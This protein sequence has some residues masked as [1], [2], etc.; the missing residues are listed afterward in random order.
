MRRLAGDGMAGTT[1]TTTTM[2]TDQ[3]GDQP[4]REGRQ[5]EP[6]DDDDDGGDLKEHLKTGSAGNVERRPGQTSAPDGGQHWTGGRHQKAANMNTRGC[7]RAGRRPCRHLEPSWPEGARGGSSERADAV[8]TPAHS[9]T[10]RF[11]GNT[12]TESQSRALERWG[13]VSSTERCVRKVRFGPMFPIARAFTL[14][15]VR[16]WQSAPGSFGFAKSVRLTCLLTLVPPADQ[17]AAWAEVGQ[18]TRR[19]RCRVGQ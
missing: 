5:L 3:R 18:R 8:E 13:G 7:R 1:T 15:R 16:W 10:A 17:S 2:T 9:L 19:S 4:G 6:D 11:W 12:L 14:R